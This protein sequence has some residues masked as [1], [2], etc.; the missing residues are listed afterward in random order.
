MSRRRLFSVPRRKIRSEVFVTGGNGFGSTN[1]KIR[2]FVTTVKSNGTAITYADSATNGGSFTIN[3]D[4]I[5]GISYHDGSTAAETVVGV[6]L[7]SS[8]LTTNIESITNA[9]RVVNSVDYLNRYTF[10][11]SILNLKTGDVIRA[12][13]DGAQNRTLDSDVSFRITRIGD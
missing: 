11:G 9:D 3:Q 7:N 5:Y 8:E 13:T 10:C 2:R 12:H 4:G 1:T 6:S